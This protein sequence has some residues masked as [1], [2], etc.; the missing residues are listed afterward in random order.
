MALITDMEE[1]LRNVDWGEVLENRL[2]RMAKRL[3]AA[4]Y[5][6]GSLK[7]VEF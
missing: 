6:E 4:F 3:L 1:K 2:H 5:I 7:N